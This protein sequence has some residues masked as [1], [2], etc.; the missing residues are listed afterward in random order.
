MYIEINNHRE[1]S[2]STQK[3]VDLII[4]TAVLLKLLLLYKENN[5]MTKI[6]VQNANTS[7]PNPA[8]HALLRCGLCGARTCVS[9]VQASKQASMQSK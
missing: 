5:E 1:Q 9:K 3:I 2:I 8:A 4:Y 6:I 7:E